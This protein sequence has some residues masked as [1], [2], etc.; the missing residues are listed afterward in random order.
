MYPGNLATRTNTAIQLCPVAET[1]TLSNILVAWRRT[2][3]ITWPQG[4]ALSSVTDHI[5][6]VGDMDAKSR[7]LAVAGML[8]LLKLPRFRLCSVETKIQSSPGRNV[9]AG[10]FERDICCQTCVKIQRFVAHRIPTLSW[11]SPDVLVE[12][13]NGPIEHTS[14]G[15]GIL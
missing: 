15:I 8:Q 14:G 12:G 5:P 11:I 4:E 1:T 7:R 2:Q 3:R 10:G 13:L 9:E 6:R